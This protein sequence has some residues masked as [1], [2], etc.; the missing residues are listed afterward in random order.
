MHY[1]TWRLCQIFKHVFT[2]KN[3][4]KY[5]NYV[6]SIG[7][8]KMGPKLHVLDYVVF[9]ASIVIS[10]GIGAWYARP[11]AGQQTAGKNRI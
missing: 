2:F 6:R 1:N 9:A 10:V 8:G 3:S 4:Q 5:F 7:I 11:T